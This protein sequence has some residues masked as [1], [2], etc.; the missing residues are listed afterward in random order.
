LKVNFPELYER[1]LCRH[2]QYGLNVSHL[3]TVVTC[4]LGL[5]GL[6]CGLVNVP[7]LP[8]ALPVPYLLALAWNVPVRVLAACVVF[9]A[10][11]VA[12]FLALPPLPVWLC[13][14]LVVLSHRVQ[15]WSHR[16]WNRERDMT[17]F[18][19]KYRKG[20]V[21]FVLLLLYELPILL[22][23]LLFDRKSWAA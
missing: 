13:A 9:V 3:L 5:F 23:Y 8:L 18:N 22:N 7:W 19:Q 17:E 21:L 14:L 10:L 12:G 6:I 4:Y 16:L 2:S 11:F 20:P 1:H 15:N